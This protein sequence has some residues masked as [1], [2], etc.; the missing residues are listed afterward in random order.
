MALQQI[1]IEKSVT[2]PQAEIK[3]AV[4]HLSL[5]E[6]EA[7]EADLLHEREEFVKHIEAFCDCV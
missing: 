2:Y 7:V 1:H 6:Q 4:D 3:K 5:E